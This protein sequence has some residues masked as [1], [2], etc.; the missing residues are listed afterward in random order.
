M[1]VFAQETMNEEEGDK[2]G[3]L[4]TTKLLLHYLSEVATKTAAGIETGAKVPRPRSPS[5]L[6]ADDAAAASNALKSYLARELAVYQGLGFE[7]PEPYRI[8][9]NANAS[10]ADRQRLQKLANNKWIGDLLLALVD[11]YGA[12]NAA[13]LEN[14][15][16]I[17]LLA[18][19]RG[20]GLYKEADELAAELMLQAAGR[21]SL[22][23]PSAL[24]VAP[25]VDKQLILP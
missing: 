25:P 3:A 7:L 18:T 16:I 5:S 23:D 21:L 14:I 22:T 13:Q 8:A 20:V 6:T 24:W 4:Q 12:N 2:G 10:A 9:D 17:N 15:E 19:L 1:F 11:T